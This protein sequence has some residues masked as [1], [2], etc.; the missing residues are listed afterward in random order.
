VVSLLRRIVPHGVKESAMQELLRIV[1]MSVEAKTSELRSEITRLES[2]ITQLGVRISDVE[3]KGVDAQMESKITQ[4][5]STITQLETKGAQ[6]ESILAFEEGLPLP[7]PKHLQTRVVGG[8][9]PGF[10]SSGYST[11]E[12]MDRFLA[13]RHCKVSDFRS[14]LDFGCGCGRIIRALR[15]RLP[16]ET[17]LFGT[18]IDPEAIEWLQENYQSIGEFEVNPHLP[19]SV[20]PDNTFDFIFSVSIFTHLPEAM[21][22]AWLKELHRVAKPGALL[23]VTTHGDF[24]R[25]TL[26]PEE[27]ARLDA[28]GFYYR[29]LTAPVVEG[30]PTFYSTAYHSPAYIRSEWKQWF[31]VLEQQP[32][33]LDNWQDINLLAKR[34]P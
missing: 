8:Y 34:T 1:D 17:R 27:L 18:D 6:L 15:Q 20:Y 33:G 24:H 30:L 5:Q 12:Q 7:P 29:E 25:P 2:T 3:A 13:A 16:D 26:Q 10:M 21:Q 22:F 19:P 31:D 14:I 4:L 9:F 28:A 23:I 32:N 11:L